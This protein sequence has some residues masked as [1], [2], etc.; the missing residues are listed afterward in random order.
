ME[1]EAKEIERKQ[2][3]Q[4]RMEERK[5]RLKEQHEKRGQKRHVRGYKAK[6]VL[7]EK[8]RKK[9]RIIKAALYLFNKHGLENIPVE[10]ITLKANV[11]KGTFYSFFKTKGDVLVHYLNSAVNKSIEE[12]ELKASSSTSFLSQIELLTSS[13]MKH[14]FS[15]KQLSMIMFKERFITWGKKNENEL[16]VEKALEKIIENS[17]NSGEIDGHVDTKFLAQ[18]LHGI[19]TMYMTFWL[20]G[21]IESKSMLFTEIKKAITIIMNGVRS[22]HECNYANPDTGLPSFG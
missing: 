11:G 10:D 4:I 22:Q 6:E 15:N 16:K 9:R 3:L 17:K 2:R 13:F 8:E 20:N 19:C 1:P 21:A 14:L 5:R 12:F 18:M 7:K